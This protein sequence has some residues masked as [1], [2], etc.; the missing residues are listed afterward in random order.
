[1][2]AQELI[3]STKPILSGLSV[4]DDDSTLLT[5]LNLAKNQLALE[6][7]VWLDGEEI[8]MTTDNAYTLTRTPIQILDVY[9]DNLQVRQR[10]SASYYGYFQTSPNTIRVNNVTSGL[11]LYL[12][13]YYTP[14]DFALTDTVVVPDSLLNAIQYFIAHKAFESYKSEKEILTST[15][16]YKKFQAS[17]LSY[18]A[19]VDENTDTILDVDMIY[20]KGLV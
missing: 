18:L 19:K 3:N 20:L 14:D 6:T 16:Y 9:D 4:K 5:F 2:T 7:R 10:N 15:E 13:Y 17:V 12:N 8:T 1:M 11:K